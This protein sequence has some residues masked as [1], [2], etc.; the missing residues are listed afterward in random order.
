MSDIVSRPL[1]HST[2]CE[3]CVFSRGE[4]ASF[5]PLH[6]CSCYMPIAMH[7]Q[8]ERHATECGLNPHN[9]AYLQAKQS[10]EAE[11]AITSGK[12]WDR[13]KHQRVN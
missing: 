1:Y 8:G 10:R 12:I 3:K 4:H 7:L 13:A 6:G 2:G 5:C 9:A 11:N